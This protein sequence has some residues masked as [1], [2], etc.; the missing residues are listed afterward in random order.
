[1]A[2]YDQVV[3][4]T[5]GI[6]R[7][8]WDAGTLAIVGGSDV[9]PLI[10][11]DTDQTGAQPGTAPTI[12][13]PVNGTRKIRQDEAFARYSFKHKTGNHASLGARLFRRDAQL[14]VQCFYP[15]YGGV[16]K[17][18]AAA[19]AKLVQSAY[20]SASAARVNFVRVSLREVGSSGPWYQVNVTADAFWFERK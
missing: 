9:P 17:A 19:L 20:E 5:F 12:S 8:A 15:R 14:A 10:L 11:E 2:S 6:L 1:M 3:A 18:K 16:G 4:E 7:T 13:D